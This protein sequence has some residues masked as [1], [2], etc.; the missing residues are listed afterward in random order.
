MFDSIK[1]MLGMGPKTDLGAVVAKG[2]V[3]M[4]VRSPGE[5]ASGHVK[6]SVNVPLNTLNAQLGNFKKD[7]AIITCCASGIRSGSAKTLLEANGFK[8]VYN[9]GPWGNL[10]KFEQ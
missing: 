2:A 10:K 9:G 3:I 8:E 7:K 6:G 5:Y 1:E 4:D